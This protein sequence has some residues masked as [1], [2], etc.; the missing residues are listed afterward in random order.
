[1][2]VNKQNFSMPCRYLKLVKTSGG[3]WLCRNYLI[4]FGRLLPRNILHMANDYMH[5][6]CEIPILFLSQRAEVKKRET[7]LCN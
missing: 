1:M 6:S 7:S 2:K 5:E 4:A 3:L